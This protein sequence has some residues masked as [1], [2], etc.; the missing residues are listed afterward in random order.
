MADCWE[1]TVAG[2]SDNDCT[3]CTNL[4]GT[5][6]L[7]RINSSSG[8]INCPVDGDVFAYQTKGLSCLDRNGRWKLYYHSGGGFDEWR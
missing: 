6:T 3:N 4:N 5:H 8:Q 7:T 2:I 1:L